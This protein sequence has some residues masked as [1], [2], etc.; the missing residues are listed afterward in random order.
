M[1]RLLLGDGLD[2]LFIELTAQCNE[3]CLHCY[4]EAEPARAEEIHGYLDEAESQ[5]L[6]GTQNPAG[7]Q[8]ETSEALSILLG[9]GQAHFDEGYRKL[10]AIRRKQLKEYMQRVATSG[11]GD[12]FE[13][14]RSRVPDLLNQ[15]Y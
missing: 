6:A 2:L 15:S 4:A 10:L 7:T 5:I 3:R 1:P 12:R 11:Y 14:G 9:G 13:N 8:A